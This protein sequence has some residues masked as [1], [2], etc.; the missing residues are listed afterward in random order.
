MTDVIREL[1]V[2]DRPRERM[3]MHGAETLSTAELVGLILG[4][5]TKGKNAIQLAR[6][7][8]ADGLESLAR[9]E[10]SVLAAIPGVGLAKATRIRAAF[11]LSRRI[12]ILEEPEEEA[13]P[14]DATM[15]GRDLITRC[16]T[17]RQERLGAAFLDAR[18]RILQQRELFVGTL[19]STLV[20]TRD[21]IRAAIVETDAAAVVV[22]HNHPSGD[23]TPSKEDEEFT[24]K[25]KESLRL[26]DVEL[27][28]HLV[29]GAHRFYSMKEKGLMG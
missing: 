29:I 6:E 5:G 16:A 25:L 18:H 13:V 24:K 26:C 1:P 11:E 28:D 20:S 12:G 15:L 9:R 27:I 7:L 14:Y 2:D 21:I 19:N 22:F 3:M 10:V 8:L 4:C 17:Y 23:P